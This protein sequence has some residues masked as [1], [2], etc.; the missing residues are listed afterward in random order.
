MRQIPARGPRGTVRQPP[1]LC[2]CVFMKCSYGRSMPE[3]YRRHNR[4]PAKPFRTLQDAAE[5]GQIISVRCNLC[6][7]L[8]NYLA[9]DLVEVLNPSRPVDVPPFGCSRC[10]TAD[11]ID[12]CVKTPSTG[13]YGHLIIRRLLGVRTVSEWGNH[14]LGEEV[15]R[16]KDV[17]RR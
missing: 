3:D 5:D 6:R 4:H 2:T 9:T 16:E 7:R 17:K 12:V 15:K 1:S 11:Y 14:P 8:T 10:G 13:D